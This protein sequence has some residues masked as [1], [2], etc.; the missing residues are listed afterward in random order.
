MLCCKAQQWI[1][2]ITGFFRRFSQLRDSCKREKCFLI[3]CLTLHQEENLT[4]LIYILTR[5]DFHDH[6]LAMLISHLLNVQQ[7]M[8]IT[9]MPGP[10]VHKDPG[11][12]AAA[13]HHQAIVEVGV[14]CIRCLHISHSCQVPLGQQRIVEMT[15]PVSILTHAI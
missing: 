9:I 14:A 2:I 13:V 3:I 11:A 8:R 5:F 6:W 10:A 4:L 12:A 7:F 15:L 1:Y